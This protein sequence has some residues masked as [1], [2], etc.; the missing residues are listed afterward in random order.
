MACVQK[1]DWKGGLCESVTHEDSPTLPSPVSIFHT[2]D[3][4]DEET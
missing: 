2:F 4:S 1:L 3:Q